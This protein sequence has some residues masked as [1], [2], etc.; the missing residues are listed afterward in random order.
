MVTLLDVPTSSQGY[1][2]VCPKD[3]ERIQ[4]GPEHLQA[5][6]FDRVSGQCIQAG[7][8]LTLTSPSVRRME[9]CK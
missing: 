7:T 1:R 3:K 9:S 6:V 5:C 8:K 4:P 2:G